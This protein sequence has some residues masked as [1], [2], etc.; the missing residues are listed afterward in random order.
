MARWRPINVVVPGADLY[1]RGGRLEL[2][3]RLAELPVLSRE[4]VEQELATLGFLEGEI[5]SA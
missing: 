3:N 4:T 1:G 5:G 2:G